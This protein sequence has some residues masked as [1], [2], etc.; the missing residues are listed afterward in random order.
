[1]LADLVDSN[2]RCNYGGQSLEHLHGLVGMVSIAGGIGSKC[3]GV[4]GGNEK[5]IQ[6]AMKKADP[7]ATLFHTTV[8]Q[9]EKNATTG[10]MDVHVRPAEMHQNN[11][12]EGFDIVIIAT[13]VELSPIRFMPAVDS[14]LQKYRETH[15]F[16]RCFTTFVRGELEPAFFTAPGDTEEMALPGEII[17]RV[18]ST[19]PFYSMAINFPVDIS[20]GSEARAFL[21]RTPR[22]QLVWKVFGPG[23]LEDAVLRKMFKNFDSRGDF[24]LA[25]EDWNAYPDYKHPQEFLPFVLQENE[26]ST[27]LYVNAI[28]QCASAMEMS[29]I[30]G[31]NC[32]N[33][34]YQW[35][36]KHLCEDVDN[37]CP[38]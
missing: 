27:L 2:M 28:E 35:V 14:T 4:A 20:T 9:I 12:L 18:D 26:Q 30:A 36:S 23:P 17:T 25:E 24:I 15:R 10:K 3:F 21:Q 8:Q 7:D 13:P 34:A 32:A 29:A 11:V 19:L 16:R 1:M 5:V 31:K 37:G 6:C 38:I 33:L 22:D